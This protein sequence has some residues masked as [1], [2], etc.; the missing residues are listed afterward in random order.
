MTIR[1]TVKTILLNT[2]VRTPLTVRKL[3]VMFCMHLRLPVVQ[4]FH[5]FQVSVG[6]RQLP[7]V[8]RLVLG[9]PCTGSLLG[10][11]KSSSVRFHKQRSCGKSEHA[12]KTS[13]DLT[14]KDTNKYCSIINNLVSIAFIFMS[15]N[16]TEEYG[17][18]SLLNELNT[19]CMTQM[20]ED[21]RSF[22][23]YYKIFEEIFVCIISIQ[24]N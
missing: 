13:H 3:S 15:T 7:D 16:S 2:S 20:H 18:S 6:Y 5:N 17:Y 11:S 9:F 10:R 23:F 22:S 21:L 19:R 8:C 12:Q 24:N 14:G 1:W 4:V